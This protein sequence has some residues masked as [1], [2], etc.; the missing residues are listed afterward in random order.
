MTILFSKVLQTAKPFHEEADG[1]IF[2]GVLQK[3]SSHSVNLS[4]EIKGTV[5]VQCNRCGTSLDYLMETPLRLTIS[6]QVIETK[7]DLDI[8]EFLDGKINLSFILQSEINALKS[9]YH[10]C[11]EC[12]RNDASLEVEF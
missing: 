10:Y 4:G 3:S 11:E 12:D 1:V 8:I 2:D 9:A 6:D 7:D 5:A